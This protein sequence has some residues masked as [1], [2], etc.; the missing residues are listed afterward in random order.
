MAINQINNNEV[1][2]GVTLT[3]NFKSL[4]QGNILLGSLLLADDGKNRNPF[5]FASQF[6]AQYSELAS[7]STNITFEN[8]EAITSGSGSFTYETVDFPL[9]G[10]IN[11][12]F[13]YF[14]IDA[15]T[16]IDECN[17]SSINATVFPTSTNCV[18]GT[19]AIALNSNAVLKTRDLTTDKVVNFEILLGANDSNAI[20]SLT[21]GTNSEQLHARTGVGSDRCSFT[22]WIDDAN[23]SVYVIEN[24]NNLSVGYQFVDITGW[25]A[26]QIEQTTPSGFSS[27]NFR[28]IRALNTNPSSTIDTIQASTDGGSTWDDITSGTINT[29]TSGDTVRLRVTGNAASGE[30]VVI[31]NFGF[32]PINYEA[33]TV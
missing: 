5:F 30:V 3:D 11:K 26:V 6:Q 13:A 22:L 19:T 24:K 1:I 33:N 10:N 18:E 2:N 25:S 27:S 21:D 12:L 29:V 16:I 15:H 8:N 31:S 9:T 23:N 7:T 28:F 20:V 17:D 14:S 32:M 4:A